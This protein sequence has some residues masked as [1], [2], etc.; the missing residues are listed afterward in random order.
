MAILRGHENLRHKAIVGFDMGFALVQCG[1]QVMRYRM[2][3]GPA[4]NLH[5][6]P[7]EEKTEVPDQLVVVANEEEA[8][9][10]RYASVDQIVE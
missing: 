1:E 6:E 7:V 10:R 4:G 5:A 3:I 2:S 9:A 8:R